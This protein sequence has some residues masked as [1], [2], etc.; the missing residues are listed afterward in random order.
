MQNLKTK[1]EPDLFCS[2]KRKKRKPK[3]KQQNQIVVHGLS[4]NNNGLG[5]IIVFPERHRAKNAR[6]QFQQTKNWREQ[7]KFW[8]WTKCLIG[9]LFFREQVFRLWGVWNRPSGSRESI[10]WASRKLHRQCILRCFAFERLRRT[11]SP[12]SPLFEIEVLYDV[13]FRL[14]IFFEL[15]S[16][17]EILKPKVAVG[18]LCT[19]ILKV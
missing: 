6:H 15:A 14:P 19:S 16:Q 3:N 8:N 10:S 12:R 1:F 2:G 18:F 9:R 5:S 11:D 7:K 17:V 13:F 4:R